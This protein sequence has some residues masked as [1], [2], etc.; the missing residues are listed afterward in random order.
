MQEQA[1]PRKPRL[2]R[3]DAMDRFTAALHRA[4]SPCL[5][6]DP[7][8][9]GWSER[10]LLQ[11]CEAGIA[12]LAADPRSRADGR[13]L[14]V[15]VGPLADARAGPAP[16]VAQVIDAHLDRARSFFEDERGAPGLD[17][18]TPRCAALNRKG[19]PLRTRAD[20]GH[21]VLRLP[22]GPYGG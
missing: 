16:R 21:A 2:S 8:R 6:P 11:V 4:L 17:G 1:T 3:A 22:H 9:P 18:W 14:A 19:K 10:Y 15:L 12:R 7:Q 13:A 5:M 20:L